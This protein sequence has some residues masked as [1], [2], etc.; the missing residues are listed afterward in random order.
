[1]QLVC[2]NIHEFRVQQFPTLIDLKTKPLLGN[3]I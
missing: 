1:M 3:L 2:I